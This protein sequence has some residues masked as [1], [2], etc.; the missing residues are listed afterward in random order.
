LAKVQ[1]EN[2]ELK[3]GRVYSRILLGGRA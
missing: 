3:N 2:A 1:I